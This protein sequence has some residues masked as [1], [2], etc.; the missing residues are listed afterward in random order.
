MLKTE[1]QAK[2]KN[3]YE[4]TRKK[5]KL[6][7]REYCLANNKYKEGDIFQD[8]MGK[9]IIEKIDYYYSPDNP[10]CIYLGIELKKDGTPKKNNPKRWAYQCN[11]ETEE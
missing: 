3:I 11:E 4:E 2:I 8:H 7:I 10:C 1:L 6:V 5:E 9:I